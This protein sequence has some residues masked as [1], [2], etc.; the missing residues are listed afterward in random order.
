MRTAKPFYP[1]PYAGSCKVQFR[2]PDT[3]RL[4]NRISTGKTNKFEAD[5]V[6]YAC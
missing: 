2:D 3:G 5:M 1:F 6:A 4:Q